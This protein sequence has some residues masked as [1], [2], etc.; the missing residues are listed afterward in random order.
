MSFDE[1]EFREKALLGILREG[2][3]EP[4][5]ACFISES[6]KQNCVDSA[7][8]GYYERDKELEN[9]LANN[10]EFGL[11]LEAGAADKA[12]DYEARDAK[13]REKLEALRKTLD[14][15]CWVYSFYDDGRILNKWREEDDYFTPLIKKLDEVL[16]LVEEAKTK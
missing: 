8:W 14:E 2:M 16:L 13:L 9:L 12:R 5:N 6:I 4:K 1:K 7:K 3:N 11:G 10:Q 15:N